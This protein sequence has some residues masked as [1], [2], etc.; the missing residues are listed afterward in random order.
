MSLKILRDNFF[1]LQGYLGTGTAVKATALDAFS[2]A[3]ST[4]TGKVIAGVG[5]FTAMSAILNT[6][7]EKYNLTYDAAMK[8]TE[9][10][11]QNVQS[12][13]S[14]IDSLNSQADEVRNSLT[15]LADAYNIE[16]TGAETIDNLVDKLSSADLSLEDEIQVSNIAAQ[17]DEL[18]RQL[19][20]KEKLLTTQQKEA[21]ANAVDTLGRGEKSVAQ[22]V[23]Q[24]VPGGRRLHP[25]QIGNVNVIDAV[26]DNVDAISEYEEKIKEL[27]ITQYGFKPGSDKWN[28]AQEDIDA[29]NEAINTL[30]SD[31]DT[32][33]PEL[34]SL[35]QALSVDGAGGTALDGYE[36][37][38]KEIQDALNS[39]NNMDLSPA[40]QKLQS[41]KDFFE[42]T[43]SHNF[44]KN[45][46]LEVAKSGGDVSKALQQAGVDIY[47]LGMDAETVNR[48]FQ[49]MASS[50]QE[51]AQAISGVDG[52][53]EGVQDAFESENAGAE[54]SSM[55]DYIQ[56]AK[57]LYEAGKVGTDDF[58]TV[59]QWMVPDKIN[60]D[61]YKYD[62]DAYVAAWESAYDRVI[63]YFDAENPLQ[64]MT[65]F[66]NDL[67]NAGKAFNDNGDITWGFKTSAEAADALGISVEAVEAA[68]HNL[69]DYGAEFD[70]V[71]FSGEGLERY[72]S[73]LDNIKSVYE[74]MDE[75]ESK[76]RLEG[77]I[78]G[79]E[80]EYSQYEQDLSTLTEDQIVHI[81]FEYDLATIQQQIDEL[82]KNIQESGGDVETYAELNAGKRTYR[83]KAEEGLGL[84][85]EGVQ[86]PVQYTVAEDSISALQSQLTTATED[87]KVQIQ[88][89]ISNIYDIQNELLNA[90]DTSGLS[91]DEFLKT[92][93]AQ[94]I[95]SD[96]SSSTEE[97][98]QNV[99][100]ILGMD[101][102]ELKIKVD[103]DTTDAENK[104]NGI[105]ANDGKHI[106][107]EVDAST[108]QVQTQLDRLQ[109][110]QT[111]TFRAEVDG[112]EQVI[113]AAKNED[114][115]ITYTATIDGVEQELSPYLSADGTVN[116][117]LGDTPQNV[118]D[119]QGNANYDLGSHPTSAP[120]VSGTANYSGRFP[121]FAPTLSG[122]VNYTARIVGSI[123]NVG[124]NIVNQI[125]GGFNGTAH[126][127]GTVRRGTA[128]LSGDWS[129]PRNETA[130]VG[131]LG[132]ET[133]IRNG[134][135]FTVGDHGAEFADIRKGDVI[136]NHK[137]TEELFKNGYVTSGG[138]R[139]QVVGDA[140]L[141]GSA[142]ANG[143]RIPS[144]SSGG[145]SGGSSSNKT[146]QST[147]NA[148]Q[149]TNN[150]ANAVSEAADEF[151][152]KFDE[153]EI[154]IDRFDR[155]LNNL[156]DSIQ[157]YSY[158]LSKQSSV[159][160]QAMNLIRNNL[161]TLQSA[162]NR[163]IQEAN[164]V[165]LEESWAAKVRDGSINIETITDENL[166]E[167]IDEY[168]DWYEKALNVQDTIAEMQ[169]EL[170]D[171]AVEKLENIDQY[172]SNRTEYN[173]NFGYLTPLTTLQEAVDKL[174]SELD[175][176][177]RDGIIIEGS[178]EWYDA[179]NTI[180]DKMQEL[181]E[182]TFKKYQDI[183]DNISR[184]SDTLDNSIALKEARDEP[185]L[186]SDYQKQIE[187][188]N[189]SIQEM[190]EKRQALLDKQAIYD[191]GSELYDDYADQIAEID[192]DIYGLLTNIEDLKDKIWEVRWQ[193]FFDGQE[194]L[195]DLVDETEEFRSYLDSKAFVGA[196][197]GLTTEGLT[198]IAL[199]S[200]SMN[201]AKQQI[202]NYQEAL[203][204]LN[205]DLQN[206]NISTS[207]Y[208]E[209]Q[210]DFLEQIRNS[211][212]V[213]EDYKDEITDLWKGMLEK[214]NEVMQSSID[215]HRELLEA[216]KNNDDY[217]R[218]VRSQTKDINAIQAQISALSG[219]NN[220][221]AKAE[222]KRLQA[223]LS[224]AEDQLA[225]TQQDRE[226][227][228][229]QSGYDALS[230]DLN[231]ALQNTLDEVTYNAQKQEQVISEML[232]NVLHNY[233]DVYSKINQIIS[234]TGFTPS[235]DFQ[236]NI[237]NLGDA[238][239]S[240][241]QINDSNTIAPDYTPDDFTN[242]NTGQIQ[243]GDS[244]KNNTDIEH[245]IEKEPNIDNRP[246]AL[247]ELKPSSI[248]I[249]EGK[250]ASITA[251][252]R[253]TDAKNK[254]VTWTSSNTSV[255]TVSN[256]TVKGIKPG[257][258]TITCMATDGS[259]TSATA[260]VTVT[261]KPDPPPPPSSSSGGDGVPRV[262]D[263]VTYSG[264]YYYDSWGQRPAGNLYSGVPGG[265]VIDS[266]SGS[267]YGGAS[268]FHGGY[269]VHIRSAD[270]RYGDLGWVSL[271]QISG[272]AKGLKHAK[273]NEIAWTQEEGPEIIVSPST[274][275][276][277]TKIN[278]GDSVIPNNLTENLFKWGAINPEKVMPGSANA[279][280]SPNVDNRNISIENH[281]DSLL[282]VNGDVD[283]EVFPGVKKMVD[284]A[285]ENTCKRLYREAGLMGIRKSL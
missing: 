110:D 261:K 150:A 134:R 198:N 131:E 217:S 4:T 108:D 106:V 47:D 241:N 71:M 233:Q 207:E 202:R 79:W 33:V 135:F 154:W 251:N 146:A 46:M 128:L 164:S 200:Q 68:M 43:E 272:Y 104:L 147:N 31:V 6:L 187:L 11:V 45:E 246:V 58:Q 3:M 96:L 91:W 191:V 230:D 152:E 69:E 35:L 87:E 7:A 60:E 15:E 238:A 179:Q 216:K 223:Q 90:F 184:I 81:E 190:F 80:S 279:I 64:S 142:Y 48:Y 194:A 57:E 186:E 256:G 189:K 274:G 18:E 252:V 284:I 78:S 232:N 98:M 259:G 255:A 12:T 195:S 70:D 285:Y 173:D 171:L 77:L 228:V 5:A 143:W 75:G 125:T 264:S 113:N 159:S 124:K 229:R 221:S 212:G 234:N 30:M 17:N 276:V 144:G 97:A 209:Q 20:L 167:K 101:V 89:E 278:S 236:Q 42:G 240:Q 166:K 161:S 100:E 247:I 219:V 227:E 39:V 23:S 266:Y 51:A 29:Y 188:N 267:E 280:V 201:A 66:T 204:K 244:I 9:A 74:S 114:G 196:D 95:L 55:A 32:K 137:Q 116:Y 82:Q 145:S 257:S 148:A 214:E 28:E 215:K 157:T 218:N 84:N 169:Q 59:A 182:A 21:A 117:T 44:L 140:Y 129:V 93:D 243:S 270:G 265:V 248:S 16:I 210:K 88:A 174:T 118:P 226:Y 34:E 282:T 61:A 10:S 220:E 205:E 160:D 183:I 263:V 268:R 239:G 130:L 175:K 149:A 41:V 73:A 231:E 170:I 283:K 199:I 8:N 107:M 83:D 136:L 50:A 103:A 245:E 126:A 178:N 24:D 37:Q 123:G 36:K 269:G 281:Y 122:V 273:E 19:N 22:E 1:M 258:A 38:F 119:A 14:E 153:V 222:L 49:E 127:Y 139:A 242:V 213:V 65:N 253:P 132:R 99:A 262:G 235:G 206:G 102:E 141:E 133:V 193:P 151:K 62:A 112:V 25:D 105:A 177:V 156:T 2:K 211:V 260:G 26:K 203:K 52:S 54:W 40:E 180:A 176:Q 67:V 115:T 76:N 163:Y 109:S 121:S 225:Q 162:Y 158:D 172:F 254:E 53:F 86:I 13:Q 63:R 181:L 165:G 155:T 92:D 277:L 27:E 85:Q 120:D 249:E 94:S 111:L 208:E 271:G 237:D 185:V 56:Q 192:D 250:T 168:Q 138:G 224:E 72:K 197:G 275:A